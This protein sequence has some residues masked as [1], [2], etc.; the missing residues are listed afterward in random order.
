MAGSNVDR[1]ASNNEGGGGGEEP[2]SGD[3]E[4]PIIDVG[5][6]GPGDRVR[7]EAGGG[8]QEELGVEEAMDALDTLRSSAFFKKIRG[9]MKDRLR[10]TN[11]S[12]DDKKKVFNMFQGAKKPDDDKKKVD[13]DISLGSLAKNRLPIVNYFLIIS[14]HIIV[15]TNFMLSLLEGYDA[16]LSEARVHAQFVEGNFN[17]IN[18]IHSGVY[19]AYI[20]NMLQGGISIVLLFTRRKKAAVVFLAYIFIQI[21]HVMTEFIMIIY[22]LRM[23]TVSIFRWQDSITLCFVR[24]V[25]VLIIIIAGVLS[26]MQRYYDLAG[27]VPERE[28][29]LH[30]QGYGKRF[31]N[32]QII[33]RNAPSFL[34]R[35]FALRKATALQIFFFS[36][37]QCQ[38]RV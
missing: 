20:L 5:V 18:D 21:I 3:G 26:A 34:Q 2:E 4:E 1:E 28:R 14:F 25:L 38:G 19:S 22:R 23:T 11:A 31:M 37:S 10:H 32:D 15:L 36:S 35:K 30:A 29:R 24:E 12:S 9:K 17:C 8:L 27:P 33:Y 6:E 16:L 7:E 13:V